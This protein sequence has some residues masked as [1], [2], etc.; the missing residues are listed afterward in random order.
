AGH[1]L[2]DQIRGPRADNHLP[3][4]RHAVVIQIDL[5]RSEDF[6]SALPG[7]RHIRQCTLHLPPGSKHCRHDKGAGGVNASVVR[8]QYAMRLTKFFSRHQHRPDRT[9]DYG[10]DQRIQI[11]TLASLSVTF[12]SHDHYVVGD[13]L[14]RDY[15]TGNA[16]LAVG[17]ARNALRRTFLS[18]SV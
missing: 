15:L 3:S 5:G 14:A 6:L 12:P 16:G 9:A 18:K 13:S 1:E 4:R 8:N 2:A 7:A 17:A 11:V 10:R